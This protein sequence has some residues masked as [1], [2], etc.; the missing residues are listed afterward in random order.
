MGRYYPQARAV[1][2]VV[3]DGFGGDDSHPTV[4]HVLPVSI[5]VRLNGYRQADT[6]DMEFD[7]R[8]F[9]FSPELI[10]AA[11][12]EIYLFQTAGLVGDVSSY[13]TDANLTISGL[14]DDDGLSAGDTGATFK[15]SGRDYTC[16]MLDKEWPVGKRIPVGED[17]DK[18]VQRLV[19]E[20]TNHKTAGRT[21]TVRFLDESDVVKAGKIAKTTTGTVKIKP[22]VGVKHSRTNKRG[23]PVRSGKN[24]W[25]VIYSLCLQH[26]FIAYVKGTDVIISKPHVLNATADQVY[27]VAYGRNL[28]TL[29]IDRHMGREQVPQIVVS[30]YD[31]DTQSTIEAAWPDKLVAKVSGDAKVKGQAAAQLTSIGTVKETIRRYVFPGIR[32]KAQLQEIAKTIYQSLGRCEAK[33]K[34]TTADLKDLQGADLILMRPGDA[35]QIGFDEVHIEQL[36]SLTAPQREARMRQLGYSPAVAQLVATEFDRINQFRHPWYVRD[37]GL[38]W[39]NDKG[40]DVEAEGIN[41]ISIARDDK[42]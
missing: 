31:A 9:P 10:R 6:F 11:G 13:A 22:K 39:H 26:G 1:L 8:Q 23:I 21:L 14:V 25:D 29:E 35:V 5:N 34:F 36:R 16:L 18:T 37:V 38:S 42:Q 12:V 28:A 17:L 19:D 27:R 2:K 32:D 15:V 4:V 20:C 41:F 3:F 30:S 40:L 24:Y 33:I 7:S